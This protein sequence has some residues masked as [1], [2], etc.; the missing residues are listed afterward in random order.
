M[1]AVH[2]AIHHNHYKTVETYYAAINAISQSLSFSADEL[3]RIYNQLFMI[4]VYRYIILFFHKTQKQWS[5]VQRH[6]TAVITKIP[7]CLSFC[8][9]PLS[10]TRDMQDTGMPTKRFDKNTGRWWWCYWQSV[11]LCCCYVGQQWFGAEQ[12]QTKTARPH[13]TVRQI[14]L[15]A[16]AQR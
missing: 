14:I 11:A 1:S 6:P 16:V 7:W 12:W 13:N 9:T 3:K 10:R 15:H 8:Y 2:I 5:G 4:F